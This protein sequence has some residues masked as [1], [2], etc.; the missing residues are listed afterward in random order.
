MVFHALGDHFGDLLET[1][2][3]VFGG[4][5]AKW[6]PGPKH[7]EKVSPKTKRKSHFSI[8]KLCFSAVDF[9]LIFLSVLPKPF[10]HFSGQSV[11]NDGHLGSVF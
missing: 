9:S 7:V 2:F 8:T 3:G 5:G 6:H 1:L 4:L 10:S 11:Q